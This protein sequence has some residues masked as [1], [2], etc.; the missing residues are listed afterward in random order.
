MKQRIIW[1]VTIL[2]VVVIS[3]G[4]FL[5]FNATKSQESSALEGLINSAGQGPSQTTSG[6][7]LQ[8]SASGSDLQGSS[9][10]Q[11]QSGDSI[12]E[13]NAVELLLDN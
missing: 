4:L 11:I 2:W 3:Y 1:T 10:G 13:P 9:A 5:A 8:G 12:S 7:S 6:Q